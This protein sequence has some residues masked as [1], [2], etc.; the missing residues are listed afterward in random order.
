MTDFNVE[1]QDSDTRT[2]GIQIL[3][4]RIALIQSLLK[5]YA[6]IHQQ[7]RPPKICLVLHNLLIGTYLIQP[8]RVTK[9]DV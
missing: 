5:F 3:T 7:T 6:Q 4:R 9:V 8:R 1:F 2:L